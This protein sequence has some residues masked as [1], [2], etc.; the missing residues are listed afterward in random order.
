MHD[1]SRQR[2]VSAPCGDYPALPTAR[3][4]ELPY[5]G[6]LTHLRESP[7]GIKYPPPGYE[8]LKI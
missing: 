7:Q 8:N 1:I 4:Q 5:S 3:I 2:S 6:A